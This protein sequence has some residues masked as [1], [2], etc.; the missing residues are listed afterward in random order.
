M[1]PLGKTEKNLKSLILV[2]NFQFFCAIICQL[3]SDYSVG[4]RKTRMKVNSFQDREYV[5][6]GQVFISVIDLAMHTEFDQE[7]PSIWPSIGPSIWPSTKLNICPIAYIML[8]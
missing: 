3:Y 8:S 7:L 4:I 2:I 6:S 1:A 5:I